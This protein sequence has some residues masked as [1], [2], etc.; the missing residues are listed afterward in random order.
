MTG[1]VRRLADR[2][3]A[4]V[5][6]AIGTTAGV[7]ALVGSVVA[8]ARLGSQ[9]FNP[10]GIPISDPRREA[11]PGGPGEFDQLSPG[12]AFYTVIRQP[13][14]EPADQTLLVIDA[15][16]GTIV[17]RLPGVGTG[18]S[19]RFTGWRGPDSVWVGAVELSAGACISAYS[20]SAPAW[21]F[22]PDDYRRSPE[23]AG[24]GFEYR[25]EPSPDRLLVAETTYDR[26]RGLKEAYP[27]SDVRLE[28]RNNRFLAQI[29]DVVLVGW[30]ADGS[31]IVIDGSDHRPY[32][33]TRAEIDSSVRTG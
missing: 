20:A 9:P 13:H 14:G 17:G 28:D 23:D 11:L 15:V 18:G 6:A 21:E 19:L 10:D 2:K 3:P 4:F 5:A 32:R 33:I 16:R 30:A 24:V 25:T 22:A 27:I 12:G 8:V 31:L 1:V 29:G 26:S 7:L